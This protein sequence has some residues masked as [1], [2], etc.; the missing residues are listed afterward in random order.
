MGRQYNDRAVVQKSEDRAHIHK[1]KYLRAAIRDYVEQYN[2]IRPHQ[3][4]DYLTPDRVYG[5]IIR[6]FSVAISWG[7]NHTPTRGSKSL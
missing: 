6:S 5:S 2:S 4:L 7:E 1:S 3:S